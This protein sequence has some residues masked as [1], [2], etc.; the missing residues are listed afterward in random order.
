MTDITQCYANGCDI[1]FVFFSHNGTLGNNAADWC[2]LAYQSGYPWTFVLLANE[3]EQCMWG[4]AGDRGPDDEDGKP[5]FL[6]GTGNIAIKTFFMEQPRPENL[7]EGFWAYMFPEYAEG[8]VMPLVPNDLSADG[9][10]N[11]VQGT[12]EGFGVKSYQDELGGKKIHLRPRMQVLDGTLRPQDIADWGDPAFMPATMLAHVFPE[13]WTDTQPT[14]TAAELPELFR[15]MSRVRSDGGLYN[16]SGDVT[17]DTG[18]A[19]AFAL[20][21]FGV[22]GPGALVFNCSY[23][24]GTTLAFEGAGGGIR[25]RNCSVPIIL[26]GPAMN[27]TA[28]EGPAIVLED[29]HLILEQAPC[30]GAAADKLIETNGDRNWRL[31]VDRATLEGSSGFDQLMATSYDYDR[32]SRIT[33]NGNWEEGDAPDGDT[34]AI[35]GL[36][37]FNVRDPAPGGTAFWLNC[38]FDGWQSIPVPA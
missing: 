7:G 15:L 30:T 23:G 24:G 34:L 8:D 20:D 12:V 35:P 4:I 37:I 1:G 38:G 31:D 14:K 3:C 10:G 28:C 29:A 19:G 18:E 9:G 11:A 21:I 6:G 22:H 27:F 33:V 36:K 17:L 16:I 13:F 2:L 5:V 25:I 26:R 32:P